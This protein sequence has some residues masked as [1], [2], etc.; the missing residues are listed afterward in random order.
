M[1]KQLSVSSFQ[2]FWSVKG[3]SGKKRKSMTVN[4]SNK[5]INWEKKKLFCIANLVR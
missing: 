2:R 3:K 1:T 5:K 4:E